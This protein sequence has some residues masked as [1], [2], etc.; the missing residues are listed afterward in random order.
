M[1]ADIEQLLY[2]EAYLLD[3]S[4][5]QDWL[6]LLAADLR[7]WYLFARNC[8]WNWK[9]RASRAG[10][11]LFD[12]TKASLSLRIRRLNTGLAWVENPTTRSRRFISNITAE[13]EADGIVRVRSYFLLW[14]SRGF[15]DETMLV[16]CREDRWSRTDKWLLRERR[17]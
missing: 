3:C 2:H 13:N 7:Y 1:A 4:R 16:G 15:W 8:R 5:F 11:L 14:R 12:E 6:E 9:R 17:S 10:L